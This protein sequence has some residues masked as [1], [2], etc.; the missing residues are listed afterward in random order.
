MIYIERKPNGIIHVNDKPIRIF[1]DLQN[2]TEQETRAFRNFQSALVK[3]LK[4]K[5]SCISR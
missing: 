3:N 5:S 1:T 2:L 4:I